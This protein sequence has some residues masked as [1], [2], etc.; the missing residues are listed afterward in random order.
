MKDRFLE[1][2]SLVCSVATSIRKI[3]TLTHIACQNL[4]K[5]AWTPKVGQI[6]AK[7]EIFGASH[8]LMGNED[9]PWHSWRFESTLFEF[10]IYF[11]Q[12]DAFF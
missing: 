6:D 7:I 1:R 12:R 5:G 2:Q 8:V 4:S 10:P 11:P 3:G 9:A